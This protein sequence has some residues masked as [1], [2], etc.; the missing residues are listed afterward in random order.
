MDCRT[1]IDLLLIDGPPSTG[2][3]T[4]PELADHLA[5]CAECRRLSGE[6]ARLDEAW[7]A[8]SLP[9][10]SDRARD[11]FLE[12][13]RQA[14]PPPKVAGR[15]RISARWAVAASVLMAVGI[16]GGLLIGDRR[17]LASSD[18]V[19]RLVDWNLSLAQAPSAVERRRIYEGRA[20]RFAEELERVALPVEDRDLARSLLDDAPSLVAE[21][22]PLAEADRFDKLATRLVTRMDRAART[23]NAK[24]L[25][26]SATLYERVASLGIGS[27]LAAIE[28]SGSLD[29]HRLKRLERLILQDDDRIK[30]LVDLLDRAPDSSRK[31]IRRALGV[32]RKSKKP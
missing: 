21:P 19:E 14:P 5:E 16:V 17:A 18:M 25:D 12:R 8:I 23:G 7:R 15:G 10:G 29:F 30:T 2:R 1:A 6:V 24:R 11:A 22:D 31:Q 28:A 27:K 3:P 9:V 4:P 13:F 20:S 26:Q 32:K